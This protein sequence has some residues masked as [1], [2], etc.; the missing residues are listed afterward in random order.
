MEVLG[1]LQNGFAGGSQSQNAGGSERNT[2]LTITAAGKITLATR[3]A[4]GNSS[5]TTNNN[6][7]GDHFA[8]TVSTPA[9]L[10]APPSVVFQKNS[11][12]SPG[13]TVPKKQGFSLA[14]PTAS[15]M[16]VQS[17]S[18]DGALN[19]NTM[20][21]CSLPFNGESSC[22]SNFNSNDKNQSKTSGCDSPESVQ[23]DLGSGSNTSIANV[24]VSSPKS[25]PFSG[26]G[27]HSAALP[28]L[29][30]QGVTHGNGNDGR[31]GRGEGGVNTSESRRLLLQDDE[32]RPTPSPSSPCLQPRS[33]SSSP[34]FFFGGHPLVINSS[35]PL[36]IN[37]CRSADGL[38]LPP[39]TVA[40]L[41]LITFDGVD[42]E[43]P[44]LTAPPSP[45][46]A[47][48]LAAAVRKWRLSVG[49]G[50]SAR[51]VTT[52]AQ[53]TLMMTSTGSLMTAYQGSRSNLN[54]ST[55]SI[56]YPETSKLLY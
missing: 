32:L 34:V 28:R 6:A 1:T 18:V 20:S 56:H 17:A 14:I 21:K 41:P 42:S 7:D 36:S 39:P 22:N 3:E 8:C 5:N 25:A 9:M 43:S 13:G 29:F 37:A 49:G 38:L 48:L 51:D 27:D 26:G 33:E 19:N 54:G 46:E 12:V 4:N 40:T 23:F 53:R 15:P 45:N 35:H 10:K 30:H 16:S 24:A 31:G 2:T 52:A 11:T 55:M 47:L 50:A 44:E